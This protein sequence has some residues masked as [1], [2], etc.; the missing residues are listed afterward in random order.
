[1]ADEGRRETA[2]RVV[3]FNPGIKGMR[4][5]FRIRLIDWQGQLWIVA[6]D[7][8]AAIGW[9]PDTWRHRREQ[10]LDGHQW[11]YACTP[12][13]RGEHLMGF[14]SQKALIE[15]VKGSTARQAR[16]FRRWAAAL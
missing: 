5:S 1:M 7:A 15:L 3:S 2:F 16:V 10:A 8:G 9:H 14:V 6:K 12:T 13:A 4:R 11:G